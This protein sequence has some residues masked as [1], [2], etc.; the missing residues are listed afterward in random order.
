MNMDVITVNGERYGKLK[1][2]NGFMLP[3]GLESHEKAAFWD[4]ITL[5]MWAKDK[6]KTD[7]FRMFFHYLSMT[8]RP[9]GSEMHK[10]GA[11]DYFA[12]LMGEGEFVK[13]EFIYNAETTKRYQG[14][15]LQQS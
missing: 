5:F 9:C 1:N 11:H 3:A 10:D 15:L 14:K 2:F 13:G 6:K 8:V 4:V 7:L 12:L